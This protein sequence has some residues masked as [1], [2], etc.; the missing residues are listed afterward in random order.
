[1]CESAWFPCRFTTVLH[2][3]ILTTA[4]L[5]G[6]NQI[7]FFAGYPA[8]VISMRFVVG[9]TTPEK[10][11]T[12][13]SWHSSNAGDHGVWHEYYNIKLRFLICR[14]YLQRETML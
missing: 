1:M 12:V 4:S 5:D 7:R 13:A 2:S 6:H 3:G 10:N 11:K 8:M 14:Y 9:A